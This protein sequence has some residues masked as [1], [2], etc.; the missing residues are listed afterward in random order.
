V[1]RLLL[2]LNHEMGITMVIVTHSEKLAAVMDRTLRLSG[3]RLTTVTAR[4]NAS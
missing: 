4:A 3:G 2:A 1:L